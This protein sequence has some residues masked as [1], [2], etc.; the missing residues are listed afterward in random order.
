MS[1]SHIPSPEP[2]K[3]ELRNVYVFERTVLPSSVGRKEI[4]IERDRERARG[5]EWIRF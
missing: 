5:T 4:D 1:V 3:V 2:Y